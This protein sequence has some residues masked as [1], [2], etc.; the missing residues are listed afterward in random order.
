MDNQLSKILEDFCKIRGSL[1]SNNVTAKTASIITRFAKAVMMAEKIVANP[2]KKD[3][4]FD[5][6][7]HLKTS[8][9]TSEKAV[10]EWA[11]PAKEQVKKVVKPTV[12]KKR[13]RKAKK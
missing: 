12:F 3:T 5:P 11:N 9:Y 7:I 8:S 10:D 1:N 2:P 6:W 4:S 13:G